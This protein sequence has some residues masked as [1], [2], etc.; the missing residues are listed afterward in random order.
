MS[1]QD[2][3]LLLIDAQESFRHRPYYR[4][5]EVGAYIERQQALI[6]GARRAGIPVVQ[7]FHVE[8]EGPFSEA[9]GL[10]KAISPLSIEPDAVFRKRRHSALV[11]SGLDVWLVANGIRRVLISGIRTE[12]CCETTTRQASDFGY[13]VDFVSEA[14]LTFPMTDA[15]GHEWSAADIKARTELVLVNRFARIVTVEQALA[16]SGER[17]AA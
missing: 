8:N 6:D 3:A 11:G 7:I 5:E 10:V 13:H 12:Q 15:S 16:T 17:K 9:S 14:T 2:T 4:D 1:A